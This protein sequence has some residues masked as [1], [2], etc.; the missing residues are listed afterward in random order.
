MKKVILSTLLVTILIIS[1]SFNQSKQLYKEG[2]I[3]LQT[4]TSETGKAIQLATH[5]KYNHCGVLF[6]EK[7]E[8]LVYEAV[9]PVS[10]ITLADFN[11]RGKATIMRLK[12]TETS[13]TAE[14]IIKM[15]TVFKTFNHKNYDSKYNWSDDELYCSE[16]V[17][18]LYYNGLGI[19]LC[20]PR[21]LKDFDLSN[22]L[23][24]K[25]LNLKYNNN[26]PLEEPMVAPS[27]IE[28]SPLLE[29]VKQ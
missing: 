27:D 1:Y 13:L 7:N 23:V 28:N 25:Q 9:Q 17:Y 29:V 8:W 18:K 3:V 24:K 26:I 12:N 16:L 6:F 2:D 11:A 22:P 10:K 5:S 20:K 4:T 15:K 19:E 21:Q 14:N